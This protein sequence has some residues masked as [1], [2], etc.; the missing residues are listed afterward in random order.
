MYYEQF[1]QEGSLAGLRK[2]Y[3]ELLVNKDRQVT[4]SYTHLDVYKRQQEIPEKIS[5]L[6]SGNIVILWILRKWAIRIPA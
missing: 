6:W 4:V 1:L 2:E 3:N 5:I